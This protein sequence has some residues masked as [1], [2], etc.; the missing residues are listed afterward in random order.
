MDSHTLETIKK[1]IYLKD[2]TEILQYE[3]NVNGIAKLF[4]FIGE[5][6]KYDNLNCI[7]KNFNKCI[8]HDE[9]V[10]NIMKI[11]KYIELLLK[12]NPDIKILLEI[13]P[14]Y[15]N[16]VSP[17]IIDIF[18]YIKIDSEISKKI[19]SCIIPVDY[20][21]LFLGDKQRI[22]Y[23]GDVLNEDGSYI[24]NM[25]IKPFFDKDKFKILQIASDSKYK[26]TEKD[27]LYLGEYIKNMEKVFF[28][29]TESLKINWKDDPIYIDKKIDIVS[30]LQRNWANITEYFSLKEILNIN[31]TTKE[32]II[33][34]GI[35]H[36]DNW[37]KI[38]GSD[39]SIFKTLRDP[40]Y[41]LNCKCIYNSL[42]YKK[43]S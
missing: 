9:K 18:E 28:E 34:L 30:K 4:T 10:V 41:R 20:R 36:N 8:E 29:L 17:N 26:Y 21:K 3:V 39:K 32:Y 38:F 11:S 25:F 31:T 15:N 24:F 37:I 33:I 1:H 19:K 13:S 42:F 22:L 35:L 12:I 6:H 7:Y 14:D 2:V 27:L 40:E 43:S 16:V 23:S 5:L